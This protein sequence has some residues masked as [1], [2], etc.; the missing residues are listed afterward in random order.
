MRRRRECLVAAARD[1]M[2][3]RPIR[4]LANLLLFGVFVMSAAHGYEPDDDARKIIAKQ[5]K[6]ELVEATPAKQRFS[7]RVA[8]TG[9]IPFNDYERLA[10]T[11]GYEPYDDCT[12]ATF[13]EVTSWQIVKGEQVDTA[14]IAALVERCLAADRT[15][16]GPKPLNQEI[17]DREILH[18]MWQRNLD[19]V[20][21]RLKDDALL[22][23]IR[24]N[25]AEHFSKLHGGPDE[26]QLSLSGFSHVAANTQVSSDSTPV[27]T[28]RQRTIGSSSVE[29][30]VLRT[31]TRYGLSGVYVT[32]ATYLLL[33]DGSIFREPFANPYTLEVP[34]A[35]RS[36]PEEWGRW[37]RRG[38]TLVVT[39][40]GKDPTVWENWFSTRPATTN[41][42]LQ[43]RY[44]SADSFGG[45]KVTNYNTMSFERDGRFSWGS[46][47]GGNTDWQPTYSN[48]ER[49]GQYSFDRHSI[50]L[51]YNDGTIAEYAFGL[52]PKDDQ[53]FV[54]GSNHFAPI[55]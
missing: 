29:D 6:A 50:R 46:L 3:Q 28:P 38:A 51:T 13:A 45:D 1:G 10:R 43:G 8:M 31:V 49:A 20:G 35:K 14:I 55:K 33:T 19:F 40:P 18:G 34:A 52:Y 22:A 41:L 27:S 16:L 23:A 30:L 32:N 26:W 54:I 17:G 48:A 37:R 4:P 15:S 21:Q 24:A 5:V 42:R 44:K 36:Q 53:H 12:V 25:A 7:A 9:N 39:W 2:M 11:N 47:K